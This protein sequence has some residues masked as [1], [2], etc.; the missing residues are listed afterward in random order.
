MSIYKK[1]AKMQ[2]NE[3][4]EYKVMKYVYIQNK[5]NQNKTGQVLFI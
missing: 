1:K 2:W 5:T 4:I 3:C